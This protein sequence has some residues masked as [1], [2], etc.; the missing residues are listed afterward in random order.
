MRHPLLSKIA[1]LTLIACLLCAFSGCKGNSEPLK[2]VSFNIK[3]GFYG[4]TLNEVADLIKET[5]GDIVG[6]QECDFN[7]R[8]S[9]EM[10]QVEILAVLAGYPYW[11]FSPTLENYQDGQYGHGILSKYPITDSKV[12]FFE[13]QEGE[14]RNV[15]RHVIK[16]GRKKIC[17]YNTH[18]STPCGTKQYAEI[19]KMMD[20]DK[21]AI[22]V[23]DLNTRPW[24]LQGILNEEKYYA[25][26]G[27]EALAFPVPTS[28]SGSE[29][30]Y[31]IYSRET[32]ECDMGGEH[33]TGLYVIKTEASDHN[34]VYGYIKFK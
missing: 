27:G 2:I 26:N 29:I 4:K 20:Q 34:L 15:E 24:Q 21:Y 31:I 17:F 30:D 28:G 19:Q 18:L 8:R 11:Y 3:C 32:L 33:K 23:G 12:T 9:G 16:V 25:M 22:L 5:G 10:N 13:T 7:T 6:L 1:L 14:K